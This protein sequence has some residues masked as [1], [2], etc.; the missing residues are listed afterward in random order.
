M[1]PHPFLPRLTAV[2]FLLTAV[3]GVGLILGGVL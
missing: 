2:A 3:T 1:R